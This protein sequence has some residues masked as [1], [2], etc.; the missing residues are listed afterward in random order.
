ML[1][2]E[3][4]SRVDREVALHSAET[5]QHLPALAVDLVDRRRVAR[6]DEQVP[7]GV[8]LDRVEVEVVDVA[9]RP[10]LRDVR[11]VDADML[12][13]PPLEQHAPARD[14]DFLH[15]PGHE[16]RHVRRRDLAVDRDQRRVLRREQQLV[17]VTM[18][19][20]SRL[21]ARNLVVGRVED[22]PAA[23]VRAED[24]ALVPRQDGAALVRLH[25]HV[26]RRGRAERQEPDRLAMVVDDERPGMALAVRRR[27]VSARRSGDVERR[28]EDRAR[29]RA[30]R[31]DVDG[32]DGR[33]EVRPADVP[34]D[35]RDS[36][37]RLGPRQPDA[38][39]RSE[40]RAS[41]RD[42]AL[43]RDPDVLDRH[44]RAI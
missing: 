40:R 42:E 11:L 24:G 30:R 32:D 17:Q 35:R 36:R 28:E 8:E 9:G 44:S 22:D 16:A 14:V 20:A 1:E 7:V 43:P 38:G 27:L 31:G 41:Q 3:R 6:R 15:D 5:P 10:D 4:C 12:V 18:A 25:A 29:R 26:H 19:A 34:V 13:A 21:H 2:A 37:R 33:V 39:E 23:A